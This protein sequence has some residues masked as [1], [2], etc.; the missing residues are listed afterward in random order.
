MSH[1]RPVDHFQFYLI[2]LLIEGSAKL[3]IISENMPRVLWTL[4]RPAYTCGGS[5]N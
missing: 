5:G 2:Q 1:F 3:I 4:R